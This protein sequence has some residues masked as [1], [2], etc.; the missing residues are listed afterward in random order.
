MSCAND[1]LLLTTATT[2][3][4][5][6]HQHRKLN[7]NAEFTNI[8]RIH[9]MWIAIL[10][11]TSKLMNLY[12][13]CVPLVPAVRFW[14]NQFGNFIMRAP[15]NFLVCK[16][17]FFY[18]SSR[19]LPPHQLKSHV[20]VMQ[21]FHIFIPCDSIAIQVGF[22]KCCS[23]SSSSIWHTRTRGRS[24]CTECVLVCGAS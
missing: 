21:S 10:A 11:N 18:S 16:S 9:W 17:F 20:L 15:C 22:G 4:T 5:T 13:W 8:D 19:S 14:S 1:E 23:S 3:T 12:L 2:T 7:K 24:S 6:N